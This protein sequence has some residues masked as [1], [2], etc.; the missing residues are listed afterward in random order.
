M[1][2]SLLSQASALNPGA[3]LWVVP[4]RGNSRWTTKIDWYLNFQIAKSGRH[5]S[6][7][8]PLFLQKVVADTNLPE[9]SFLAEDHS[10]LLIP[11]QN[12]LPC[13]WTAVLPLHRNH[14]EWVSQLSQVWTSLDKPTFRVF[15][16]AGQNPATF[17]ELWQNHHK[18]EEFTVVLD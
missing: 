7:T 2:I 8:S 1:A 10:P 12:L 17:N 15:L 16:P 14:A 11:C 3:E 6:R 13:R 9:Y 4:D 18:F 5:Q